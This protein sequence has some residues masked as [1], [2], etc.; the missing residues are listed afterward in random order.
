MCH[1]ERRLPVEIRTSGPEGIKKRMYHI[2]LIHPHLIIIPGRGE[3][4]DRNLLYKSYDF[5]FSDH[6]ALL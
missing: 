6:I 5:T 4:P 1:H 2:D 3:D